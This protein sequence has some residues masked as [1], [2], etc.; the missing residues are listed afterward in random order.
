MEIKDEKALIERIARD[1]A[2]KA[3]AARDAFLVVTATN[4]DHQAI[5][6][7]ARERLKV[8]GEIA[9]GGVQNEVP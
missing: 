5:N 9:A 2:D 7:G 1:I 3:R 4:R 6:D 8:T